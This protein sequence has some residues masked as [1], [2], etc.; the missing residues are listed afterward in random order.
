MS[1]PFE[2]KVYEELLKP[3]EIADRKFNIDEIKIKNI[4]I[5]TTDEMEITLT[6]TGPIEE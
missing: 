2:F 5:R 1:K 6:L 3:I 4:G